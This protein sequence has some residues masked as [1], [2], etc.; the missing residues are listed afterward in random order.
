MTT[1][2]I[3]N[4]IKENQ[5]VITTIQKQLNNCKEFKISVAFITESGVTPL[6]QTLK[7]LEEKQIPGKIITSDYLYFSQ[8]KALRKLNQFKNIDVKLYSVDEKE[9]GFHTKG[10][11]FKKEDENYNIIVGSSNLTHKALTTNKEWNILSEN[12]TQITDEILQTFD[13]FWNEAIPLEDCID[14]YEKAY[15]ENQIK[16]EKTWQSK[17]EFKPNQ[18]QKDFIEKL[19]HVAIREK[20]KRGLFISATGTGK[21]IAS[22]FGIRKLNP[23]KVLFLVHREQIAKQAMKSYQNLK[24]M[25]NMIH[26][27]L[28]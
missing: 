21:T 17:P 1:K 27:N 25:K 12:D 13:E 16:N 9:Y 14:K 2:L 20:Q 7:K 26:L 8:P 19:E 24:Y 4:D 15:N 23:K 22:A 11:I 5:K 18:V 10:Y 3:Q 28:M 6:L